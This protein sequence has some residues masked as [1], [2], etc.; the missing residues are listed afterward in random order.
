MFLKNDGI[1]KKKIKFTHVRYPRPIVVKKLIENRV[2]F[3]LS[4]GNILSKEDCIVLK[5]SSV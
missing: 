1:L 5:H 4:R 3:G 2:L